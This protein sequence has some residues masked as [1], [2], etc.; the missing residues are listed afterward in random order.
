[1]NFTDPIP[2]RRDDDDGRWVIE[3]DGLVVRGDTPEG[4]LSFYWVIVTQRIIKASA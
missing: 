3:D 1:M 4:A 2:Y